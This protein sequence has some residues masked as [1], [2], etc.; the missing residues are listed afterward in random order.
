MAI[1]K[2]IL[3]VVF[4]LAA[5]A[6]TII[7]L[8]QEGKS[9]G[10][11]S[12]SGSVEHNDSY[13][14][15]NKKYSLEGKLERWTKVTAAIFVLSAFILMLMPTKPSTSGTVNNATTES[16]TES[17]EV[18]T[19]GADDKASEDASSSPEASTDSTSSSAN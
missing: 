15:K 16:T 17:S 1:L 13:W 12:L 3:I 6:M 11:G 18:T 14:D 10:L 5:L 4:L 9:A 7:V 19:E 2:I 8:C